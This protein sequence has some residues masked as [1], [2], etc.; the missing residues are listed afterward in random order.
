MPTKSKVL[1]IHPKDKST[2]FLKAIYED[3]EDKTVLSEN[4]DIRELNKI[5][6]QHD[7]IMMMGHGV[8]MGLLSVGSDLFNSTLL[9]DYSNV[10]YL[11]DKDCVFIWRNADVFVRNHGLKGFYTGMFISEVK[12]ADYFLIEQV[13]QKEVNES[14]ELFVQLVKE[15]IH[16]DNKSIKEKVTSEYGKLGDANPVAYYNN[17]RLYV[18][19]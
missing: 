5:I 14:N 4:I 9:I 19:E 7:R 15:N 16:L 8:P 13:T 17:F 1:I 12:E 10:P 6:D 11:E 18:N 3:I 2:E